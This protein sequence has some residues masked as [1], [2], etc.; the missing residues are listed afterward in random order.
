MVLALKRNGT[1]VAWS[2]NH[3]GETAVPEGLRNVIA[4]AA[5]EHLSQALKSDGT[6]VAWGGNEFGQTSVPAGLSN[7]MAI[8]AGGWF[9]LALTTGNIP[10]S[11]FIYPHGRLEE[12]EREADLVFKGRVISTSAATN[13][14]FPSWGKPHA[15][16]FS[17]I[18][19]TQRKC[20][21]QRAGSLAQ[22][23]RAGCLGRRISA[24]MASI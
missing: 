12:M 13:T 23:K 4:I 9:S 19:V 20:S 1:V 11:V 10:S 17:L 15:T 24:F 22:Y 7:V 18:S 6:V 2:S 21:Y 8:A 3:S 14:S 16:R 5:D